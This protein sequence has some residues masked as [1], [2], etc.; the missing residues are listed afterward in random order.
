MNSKLE[1]LFEEAKALSDEEWDQLIRMLEVH[2]RCEISSA[3]TRREWNEEAVR[4]Y[5]EYKEGKVAAISLEE[6]L[7]RIRNRLAN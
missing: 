1:R 5:Q 7:N 2:D 4:R 3:E 6:A